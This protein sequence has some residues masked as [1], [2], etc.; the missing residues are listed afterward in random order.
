[1]AT[2]EE[3]LAALAAVVEDL[4]A[5]AEKQQ[6]VIKQT[7]KESVQWGMQQAVYKEL[8]MSFDLPISRTDEALARVG[9]IAAVTV[10]K[11]DS[12]REA[13]ASFHWW[14][15]GV[16]LACLVCA[17]VGGFVGAHFGVR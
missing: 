7:V 16:P 6:Q 3:R 4:I 12:V 11:L 1:M 2:P 15:V 9:K 10:Q 8:A 14:M 13:T 17:A 5:T